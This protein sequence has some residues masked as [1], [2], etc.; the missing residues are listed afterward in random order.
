MNRR[1]TGMGGNGYASRGKSKY[2]NWKGVDAILLVTGFI[3]HFHQGCGLFSVAEGVIK[4][5]IN[6]G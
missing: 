6:F 4:Q 5:R 3:N 2:L 1:P